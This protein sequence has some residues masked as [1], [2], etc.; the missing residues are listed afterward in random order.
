MRQKF[1]LTDL[2]TDNDL[3]K[4]TDVLWVYFPELKSTEI[5]KILKASEVYVFNSIVGAL[6][7]LG[8]GLGLIEV[9]E[10]IMEAGALIKYKYLK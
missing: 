5:S 3:F 7:V 2:I 8:L 4:N 10:I 9:L 6:G 1:N